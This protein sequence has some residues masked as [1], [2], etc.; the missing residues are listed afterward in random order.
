MINITV[1][2]ITSV[3]II[4]GIFDLLYGF[5]AINK[6]HNKTMENLNINFIHT[7]KKLHAASVG[8][9]M[10]NDAPDITYFIPCYPGIYN[11]LLGNT[12]LNLFIH[13]YDITG[14]ARVE[15]SRQFL[16][17]SKE[18]FFF[19]HLKGWIG[20]KDRKKAVK[21]IRYLKKMVSLP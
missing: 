19:M 1:L 6:K 13:E 12:K 10:N 18:Q 7:M 21:A 8:L 14:K 2:I 9:G 4:Y 20:T 15:K 17:V 11:K 16:V 5:S 3:V